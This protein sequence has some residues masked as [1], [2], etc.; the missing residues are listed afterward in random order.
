[1]WKEV[2]WERLD[3]WFAEVLSFAT[4]ASGWSGEASFPPYPTAAC[5]FIGA[6]VVAVNSC[7]FTLFFTLF[8]PLRISTLRALICSFAVRLLPRALAFCEPFLLKNGVLCV[9]LALIIY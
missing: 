7:T 2:L 9:L 6:G 3:C 4:E 1:M 8:L 5:P